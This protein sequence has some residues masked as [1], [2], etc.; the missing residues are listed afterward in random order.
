MKTNIDIKHLS[1]DEK[2]RVI[3]AIWEDLSCEDES[4]VSPTWH[5]EALQETVNRIRSG[6]EKI[7]DWKEG[8][9]VLRKRFE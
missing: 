9:A 2:L 5:Q 4:I 8:K 7:L 3:E 6:E 1:R